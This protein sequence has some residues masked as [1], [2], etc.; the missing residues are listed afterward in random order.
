MLYIHQISL[1]YHNLI[2]YMSKTNFP[3]A[4][5]DIT[6]FFKVRS[7]Y[8]ILFSVFVRS[9][10]NIIQNYICKFGIVFLLYNTFITVKKSVIHSSCLF[11]V[12]GD[13]LSNNVMLTE[14]STYFNFFNLKNSENLIVR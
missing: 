10:A 6:R 5:K 3:V 7:K 12:S 9:L 4:M 1:L 11:L 13:L 8:K 2:F 14:E